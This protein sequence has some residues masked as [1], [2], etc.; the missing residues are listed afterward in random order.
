M[1]TMRELEAKHTK[2]VAALTGYV[3]DL[4]AGKIEYDLNKYIPLLRE[5]GAANRLLAVATEHAEMVAPGGQ[6]ATRSLEEILES[7]LLLFV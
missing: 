4:G 1:A 2:A 3:E 6:Q 7:E 5:Y